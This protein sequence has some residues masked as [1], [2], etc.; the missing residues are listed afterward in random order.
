MKIPIFSDSS[1]RQI[2]ANELLAWILGRHSS[3]FK[4]ITLSFVHVKLRYLVTWHL[5]SEMWKHFNPFSVPTW[6]CPGR[7]ALYHV[8]L[9]MKGF[10]ERDQWKVLEICNKLSRAESKLFYVRV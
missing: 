6:W 3:A 7:T 1:H 4:A 9:V 2:L 10:G 5:K 8:R